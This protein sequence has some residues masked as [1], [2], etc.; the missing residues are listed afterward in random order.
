MEDQQNPCEN[1]R[2][3]LIDI[4]LYLFFIGSDIAIAIGVYKY[5]HMWMAWLAIYN[6]ISAG[7]HNII[8]FDR[9]AIAIYLIL[10]FI[11]N[12]M[13]CNALIDHLGYVVVLIII[14]L[15]G[16]SAIGISG[17][18]IP[19]R[20]QWVNVIYNGL[21]PIPLVVFYYTSGGSLLEIPALLISIPC[22]YMAIAGIVISWDYMNRNKHPE[23][24]ATGIVASIA[25]INNYVMVLTTPHFLVIYLPPAIG[26]VSMVITATVLNTHF[27]CALCDRCL[28][29]ANDV[30]SPIV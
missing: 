5:P 26:I 23:L 16:Q 7:K 29:R 30:L 24:V 6:L 1:T 12:I 9:M 27:R 2:N 15:I 25:A 4:T 17:A 20:I 19:A 13:I 21:G 10:W 14:H 18:N 22:L 11:C 3:I 28:Q 8:R